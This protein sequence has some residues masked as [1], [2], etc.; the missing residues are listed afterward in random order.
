MNALTP[1]LFDENHILRT[2]ER[3]G[4]PWF[5]AAD[6]CRCL[7]IQNPTMAVTSL[8]DDERDTL[9][10]T[11]GIPGN[12]IKN[13]INE[14]GLYALILRSRKAMTP[15][16]AQHRFR[17]WVT[18]EVLPTIRKTGAYGRASHADVLAGQRHALRLM[19]QIRRETEPGMRRSLH[20]MLDQ[21]LSGIGLDVPPLSC[22]GADAPNPAQITAPFWRALETLDEKCVAYNHARAP[23]TIAVNLHHLAGLF[24][25]HGCAVALNGHL[26][27][28]LKQLRE[29]RFIG[30]KAVNSALAGKTVTCWVWEGRATRLRTVPSVARP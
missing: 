9:C 28:A 18:G 20:A 5:V 3:D 2:V 14:S 1:F 26:R 27:N 16:T 17:K 15:G 30:I 10:L 13:I 19:A 22:I 12:P 4:E 6:V 7:E 24:A 23:E 21:T 11:E 8:D 25:D 29:P